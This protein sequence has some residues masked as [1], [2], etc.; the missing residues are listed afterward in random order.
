VEQQIATFALI[1]DL[2]AYGIRVPTARDGVGM[3]LGYEARRESAEFETD[4]AFQTGDLAGQGGATLPSAGA[5]NVRDYFGELI[6]PLFANLPGIYDSKLEFGYRYSDY[7]R[8][9]STDTYKIAGDYSPVQDIRFR[10]G[11][12]RAVRTPNVVELAAPLN[13][14][15]DGNTDPCAGEIDPT[16]GIVSGGATAAQ[17]ANDPL[18]AA[19][20]SLYGNIA[21]NPAGQYNGQRGASDGLR[22]EKADTYSFGFVLQPTAIK[23]L[24]LS[25]DYYRIKV[26][27]LIG[28]Y[29]A[30]TILDTCYTTG[31]LCD[32]IV[33]DPTAG[34]TFGSLW[35]GPNGYVVN[36]TQNTG[37]Q[38]VRGV[39]FASNYKLKIPNAGSLNFDLV[40]TRNL[41]QINEPIPGGDTY[42]CQGK[43]GLQ[44][45]TPVPK[46]R[47]KFRTTWTAPYGNDYY[48]GLTVSGQWRYIGKVEADELSQPVSRDAKLG[49]QTYIDL[50]SS[51][52]VFKSYTF[53]LGINNLL[54]NNPPIV[55]GANDLA[56]ALPS[57]FGNGN[58]F[59]QVYDSLGRY[60]FFGVTMDL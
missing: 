35:L 28:G 6:V 7:S 57:V 17:C 8:F 19:N 14:A 31:N 32:L 43:Y 52:T 15:L 59:P 33:R 27:G 40:A 42:E 41:K 29:G 20:P 55:G 48:S 22:A 10:A 49:A 60:I 25:I 56:G 24:S 51:V 44:C 12:N 38:K 11:Y 30:D 45:G 54:D 50:Y 53:R 37:S 34:L 9:K 21:E 26:D 2:D 39:D 47:H 13:V 16:T 46:W 4:V 23:N 5:F 1:G 18:I 36:T 3:V 58:T